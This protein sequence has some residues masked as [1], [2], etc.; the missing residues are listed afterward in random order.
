MVNSTEPATMLSEF[1]VQKIVKLT[2]A[3]SL[4]QLRHDCCAQMIMQGRA[5]LL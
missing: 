2:A 4:I 1:R 3:P 5:V